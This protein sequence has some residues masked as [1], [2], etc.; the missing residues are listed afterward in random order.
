MPIGATWKVLRWD[1]RPPD[2]PPGDPVPLQCACGNDAL[3]E[4]CGAPGDG[5]VGA[6]GMLLFFDHPGHTPPLGWMPDEIQCRK[7][8][9]IYSTPVDDQE[10]ANVR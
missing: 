2:E 6:N 5:V 1:S 9:R 10:A 8:G 7:C 4:T 3:V